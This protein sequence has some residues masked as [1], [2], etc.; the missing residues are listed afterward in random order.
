MYWIRLTIHQQ[1]QPQ[2][3]VIVAAAAAAIHRRHLVRSRFFHLC[4]C[5]AVKSSNDI[6]YDDDDGAAASPGDGS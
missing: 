3:L 6:D 2:Q 1:Q 5:P 4:L